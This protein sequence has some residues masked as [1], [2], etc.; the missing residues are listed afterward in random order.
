MRWNEPINVSD[1]E[2][3]TSWYTHIVIVIKININSRTNADASSAS[4]SP[5]TNVLLS[6]PSFFSIRG[7][8][9][10]GLGK[11]V[12]SARPRMYGRENIVTDASVYIAVAV[13]LW[14]CISDDFLLVLMCTINQH[15]RQQAVWR[16][17]GLDFGDKGVNRLYKFMSFRTSFN[18]Q[19]IV[20]IKSAH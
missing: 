17:M 5:S 2:T 20:A 1:G 14:I 11:G 3:G 4:S 13:V 19:I 6:T 15:K 16:W 12:T 7:S 10:A 9:S 8:V 18:E